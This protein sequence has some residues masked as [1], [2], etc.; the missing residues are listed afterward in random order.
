MTQRR[1]ERFLPD[2]AGLYWFRVRGEIIHVEALEQYDNRDI[3]QWVAYVDAVRGWTD[4]PLE[5]GQI[6]ENILTDGGRD[7]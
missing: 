7:R 3:D 2:G 6:L 4:R 1:A 5:L